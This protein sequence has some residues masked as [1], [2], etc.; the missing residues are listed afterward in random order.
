MQAPVDQQKACGVSPSAR[1]HSAGVVARRMAERRAVSLGSGKPQR[2]SC[3][4]KSS[5]AAATAPEA[6]IA[7]RSRRTVSGGGTTSSSRTR[8]CVTAGFC[9][10][11]SIAVFQAGPGPLF[12]GRG[13]QVTSGKAAHKVRVSSDEALSATWMPPD[14]GVSLFRSASSKRLS[15]A[16]RRWVAMAAATQGEGVVGFIAAWRLQ[17]GRGSVM[18][19]AC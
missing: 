2:C 4:S 19:M 15:S 17:A 1:W 8:T 3:S 5:G 11:C 9:S 6:V 14:S 10:A 18:Q 16:S 7:P 13:S 12:T